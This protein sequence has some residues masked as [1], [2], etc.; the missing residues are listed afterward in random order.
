MFYALTRLLPDADRVGNVDELVAKVERL[1]G[2]TR[3]R[4]VL[5]AA[6]LRSK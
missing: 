6:A 5:E 1:E 2:A 4:Q 3:S